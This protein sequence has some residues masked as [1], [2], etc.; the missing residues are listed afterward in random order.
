[1]LKS[2]KFFG[3]AVICFLSLIFTSCKDDKSGTYYGTDAHLGNGNVRAYA[4]LDEEGN[5]V[6]IGVSIDKAATEGLS[7][8]PNAH[9]H[10][11]LVLAFPKEAAATGFD[12]VLF[13]WNPE[14]HEPSGVYT[15]PHFDLH[16]YLQALADRQAIPLYDVD[17]TK[18]NLLP[19]AAYFPSTYFRIPGGVPGM[20]VHWLDGTAPEL[21]GEVFTHTFIFGSYNGQVTFLEPMITLAAMNN[22][23][24]E[25]TVSIKQPQK[26]ASAYFPS[27]YS[28]ILDESENEYRI[29][30][31]DLVKR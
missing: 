22:A 1:M 15:L 17:S 14:G 3:V 26:Y 30:L 21:Q 18:F 6:S 13:N 19:D 7:Q 4:V 27:S 5:P 9:N 28:Y 10:N 29:E 2:I 8:D 20:G 25:T 16:F 24:T 31:K 23:R 12:H 11:D